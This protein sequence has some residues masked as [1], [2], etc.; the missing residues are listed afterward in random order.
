MI[1]ERKLETT[2]IN[3]SLGQSIDISMMWVEFVRVDERNRVVE[4]GI[5]KANTD[6]PMDKC[7]F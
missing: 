5:E 3:G 6:I 1:K 4:I 2:N 7:L